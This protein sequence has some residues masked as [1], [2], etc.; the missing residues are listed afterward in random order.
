MKNLFAGRIDPKVNPALSSFQRST[1]SNGEIRSSIRP[2]VISLWTGSIGV[3]TIGLWAVILLKISCTINDPKVFVNCYR[4]QSLKQQLTVCQVDCCG[5][6]SGVC[7]AHGPGLHHS[8]NPKGKGI[9]HCCDF[10][11]TY[12]LSIYWDWV[13]AQMYFFCFSHQYVWHRVKGLFSSEQGPR[14]W[15][16][17]FPRTVKHCH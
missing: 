8:F 1:D 9:Y 12:V 14:L 11:E 17:T 7:S 6:P 10:T 15:D 13:C 5:S 2:W 16:S 4:M 3:P